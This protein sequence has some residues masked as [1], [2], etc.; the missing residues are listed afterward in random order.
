MAQSEGKERHV[1][2]RN[3]KAFFNFTVEETLEVGIEL[4]GTEVKSIKANRVSFTDSYA[5][6]RNDELWLFGLH[7]AEYTHGN[8]NNH[9]P[10][11]TRKLLAHKS[12]TKRLR[13]KIDERG[14]TMV[15]L[16][17]YVVHG[18]I[19][20]EL[21]LCKGKKVHDK[22]EAIKKRDQ[23]RDEARELRNQY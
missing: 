6:I 1:I 3:K 20:V 19:K 12:E 7:I 14:Y 23:K 10:D 5:R 13:R 21:G 4:Q 18:L 2:A 9:E 22:R 11:R 15:P 16:R 17:I 8:L